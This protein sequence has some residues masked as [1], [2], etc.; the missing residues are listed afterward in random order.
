M[1][2]VRNPASNGMNDRLTLWREELFRPRRVG[3]LDQLS[4]YVATLP[5]GDR[6]IAHVLAGLVIAVSV[7][8]MYALEQ[9][10]L[11]R[12]P[13]YG[14][15]LIEGVVG[16][17]RFVNPLLAV[18]DADRDLT[19]LMYAGLMGVSGDGTLIPVLAERYSVSPDGKTYTFTLREGARF[20]NGT[21][22]TADDVVFT[23]GK[24]QDPALKSP[25]FAS[26]SGVAALAI[27]AH[28]IT[29]TLTKPYAPFLENTTLGILPASLWRGISDEQFPFSTLALEPIGAGPFKVSSIT[30]DASGL[31]SDYSLTANARYALGRPYLSGIHFM[32]FS[33]DDDLAKALANGTILSAYGHP[34]PYALTTPY[35]RVFGVFFNQSMNAALARLE[36]RK[37]LSFA[38]D[39]AYITDNVLGGYATAIMG[40]VPPGA[41]ITETPVE[42][43]ANR[44]ASAS[45]VLTSAGWEYDRVA[46]A[47][48][49][50]GAKLSLDAITIK[51]SNVSELKAVASAIKTDWEK[52]GVSVD[53]ELYE[54][55]DLNQNVIRPRKYDA[56]LFGMVIGRDKD[57]YAF[58]DSAERNDPGLN[59]ALY[60]NKSV[61]TLLEDARQTSDPAERLADLQKIED[62]V[63]LDYPAA[64]THAPDFVYAVPPALGGIVLPQIT[65]PSDRFATAAG[66]YLSTEAVWPFLVPN[67]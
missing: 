10:L 62:A 47:W 53:I 50:T 11:V 13:T 48:K 25:Q 59:I 26:W 52:L 5:Q 33:R 64:F 4:A 16:S 1:N 29:F 31:I 23:V 20:S 12:V 58:W 40:P 65:T 35:A 66:W 55:G 38:I 63:A 3:A 17:P 37:A 36:V 6:V 41:N 67:R 46:R 14:G 21:P 49:N 7:M 8:S 24:A 57:L 43:F 19:T 39:R 15:T 27:D 60:A 42:T 44:I 28:T 30:R 32:F 9:K 18:S 51:T 34:A 2:P 45:E 56:L 22:I 54:P 61:D